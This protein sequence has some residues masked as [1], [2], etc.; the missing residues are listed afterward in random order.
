MVEFFRLEDM[1]QEVR[2]LI[3]MEKRVVGAR[4]E[5]KWPSPGESVQIELESPED[6]SIKFSLD[7]GESRR[8]STASLTLTEVPSRKAKF[9]TRESN[10]PLIR[11]DY[12]RPPEIQ[13]HRNP[14]GAL[15]VGSHVHF[16]MPGYGIR[17]AYPI[18]MQDIIC[19]NDA[20]ASLSDLF[21]GF[22]AACSIETRLIVSMSIE[23]V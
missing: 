14:D 13:R 7:L 4:N 18:D 10:R 2:H 17:Y 11:V 5:F 6:R 23:G 19:P 9:Q 22:L 1:E 3:S 16:A 21:S 20:L 12:G 15:I 8:R